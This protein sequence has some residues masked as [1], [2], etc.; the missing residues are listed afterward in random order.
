MDGF[1]PAGGIRRL[2]DAVPVHCMV[3]PGFPVAPPR[4]VGHDAMPADVLRLSDERWRRGGFPAAE[5]RFYRLA[6][7]IVA[8][9]GLVFDEAGNLFAETRKAHGDDAIGAAREAIAASGVTAPR[10]RHFSRA[11]LCKQSGA[12]NYGH[13]LTEML[14]KAFFARKEMGLRDYLHVIPNPQGQLADV[15][16]ESLEM[17]GI[18]VALHLPLNDSPCFFHELIV[19]EGLT[20]HSAYMSPLVGECLNRI[21]ADVPGRGIGR[22][23]LRRWPAKARDFED[24]DRIA[25][26]LARHGFEPVVTSALSFREQIAIIRDASIVVGTMGAAM[27]NAVFCNPGAEICVFGPAS[28]R[29]FFY[30]FLSNLR[31]QVYYEIRCPESGPALGPLPWDRKIEFSPRNME[32]FLARLWG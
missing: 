24:E 18:D 17:A 10:L 29:E 30:W 2:A 16:R 26:C 20:T 4:L 7:V 25:E 5:V 9:E 14:P 22:V 19:I 3:S 31:H 11:V 28:A 27:T 13:W 32:D 12:E 15:I 21:A 23:Y 6:N 8:A 1:H